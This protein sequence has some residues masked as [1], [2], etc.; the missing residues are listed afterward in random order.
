[1]KRYCLIGFCCAYFILC[2][3][4]VAFGAEDGAKGSPSLFFP[5]EAY[6]FDTVLEGTP[7]LHEFVIQNKGTAD[8]DVKKVSGG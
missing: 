2:L 1:M 7:V 5:Q 8:L 4:G 3:M 6:E